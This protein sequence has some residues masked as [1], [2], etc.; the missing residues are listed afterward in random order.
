MAENAGRDRQADHTPR[1]DAD[2]HVK[3]SW[4]ASTLPQGRHRRT[5]REI[6]LLTEEKVNVPEAWIVPG[7]SSGCCHSPLRLRNLLAVA[8]MCGPAQLRIRKHRQ[9]STCHTTVP[10]VLAVG[11]AGPTALASGVCPAIPNMNSAKPEDEPF[12]RVRAPDSHRQT[13]LKPQTSAN[14]ELLAFA[15]RRLAKGCGLTTTIWTHLTQRYNH[16]AR[17]DVIMPTVLIKRYPNR[18]LYN[19][20]AKRYHLD[21]VART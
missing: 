2:K 20:D 14:L 21:S 5:G 6:S 10:G 1:S 18:K 7:N 16:A 15:V 19:T 4:A 13:R 12:R 17:S 9:S 11:R 3:A 8:R